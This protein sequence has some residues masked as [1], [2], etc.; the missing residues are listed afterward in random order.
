[1]AEVERAE[2]HDLAFVVLRHEV[3]AR[4]IGDLR[5]VDL[6]A[7][8]ARLVRDL[9]PAQLLEQQGD[10][11]EVARLGAPHV[12]A[13]SPCSRAPFTVASRAL[14]RYSASASA[15]PTRRDGTPSAPW[16]VRMQCDRASSLSAGKSTPARSAT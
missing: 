16:W 1:V 12:H 7:A 9:L 13:A 8:V 5:R 4:R 14:S 6:A 3:V 2:R 15:D 10:G 11:V